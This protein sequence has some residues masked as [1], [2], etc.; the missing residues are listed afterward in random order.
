MLDH[1]RGVEIDLGDLDADLP[2]PGHGVA[3]IDGEVRD[4]LLE[5]GLVRLHAARVGSTNDE[6]DVLA[7][8]PLQHRRE[9]VHHRP[10]RHDLRR[11][12]LLAAEGE[13]LPGQSRRARGRPLD[14][15]DIPSERMVGSQAR[16]EDLG[17]PGDDREQVVEIVR[18]PA[19]ELS[20][21][22][23]LLRLA[24]LGFDLLL[25]RF[26]APPLRDVAGHAD[27]ADRG[28]GIVA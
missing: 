8:E 7:D 23:D 19:R 24:Q 6:L 26:G 5:L 2:T 16:Q 21:A 27:D 18:D 14:H 3:S 10:E 11:E 17:A 9:V 1:E 15:L 13:Q 4:D 25:L 28:A 20:D 12:H 22:F